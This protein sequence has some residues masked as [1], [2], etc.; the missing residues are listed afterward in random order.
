MSRYSQAARPLLLVVDDDA[1]MRRALTLTLENQGYQ[2][3]RA[4]TG[5]EALRLARMRAPDGL[6]LDMA[7][8]DMHGLELMARLLVE[9]QPPTLV[10]SANCDEQMQVRALDSGARDYVTKPFR[11]RELLARIRVLLRRPF[12]GDSQTATLTLGELRIEPAKRQ[13]F[14]AGQEVKLSRTEFDLLD[15]LARKPNGIVTHVQ[16]LHA[17]WGANR[18]R[19]VHYLRMYVKM[20]RQKLEQDPAK[21]KRLL[22]VLGVGYRLVTGET[23][24][25]AERGERTGS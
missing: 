2:V 16:L 1:E 12:A 7:L 19:D 23:T 17:V 14:V 10:L 25:P 15:A 22:T 6:I 21:P 24:E 13:V 18:L 20:L 11:E 9:R 3:Q 4:A 5:A 8:P